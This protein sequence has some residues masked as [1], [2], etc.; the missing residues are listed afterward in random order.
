MISRRLYASLGSSLLKQPHL[1]SIQQI[2]KC[3]ATAHAAPGKARESENSDENTALYRINELFMSD[4][5]NILDPSKKAK[6]LD[7]HQVQITAVDYEFMKRMYGKHSL[8]AQTSKF[9]NTLTSNKDVKKEFMKLAKSRINATYLPSILECGWYFCLSEDEAYKKEFLK[10][11][12]PAVKQQIAQDFN[13]KSP[14]RQK[15]MLS[16][17]VFNYAM[18]FSKEMGFNGV[19]RLTEGVEH[20]A[21][22]DFTM[23]FYLKLAS[24]L[25]SNGIEV[26]NVS[27]FAEIYY[28]GI[29]LKDKV[30]IDIHKV[31][32][33]PDTKVYKAIRHRNLKEMGYQVIPIVVNPQE[34]GNTG[35]ATRIIQKLKEQ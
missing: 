25:E 32:A 11:V 33:R 12:V 17:L 10:H 31:N 30:L 7:S 29:E 8:L 20:I 28:T 6:F 14:L 22:D 21:L 15:V 27:D 16:Q 9:V 19:P 24:I 34:E 1:F 23:D 5:E 26:S 13:K 18:L 3:F 35:I 2:N 4:I